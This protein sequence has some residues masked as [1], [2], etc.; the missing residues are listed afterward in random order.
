MVSKGL[1]HTLPSRSPFDF[2]L[3]TQVRLFDLK[4]LIVKVDQTKSNA[5]PTRHL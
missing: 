3:T 5:L 1:V 4:I 2:R